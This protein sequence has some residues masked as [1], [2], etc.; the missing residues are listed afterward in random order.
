MPIRRDNGN[1]AAG[2]LGVCVADPLQ[3]FLPARRRANKV[4]VRYDGSASLGHVVQS[5]GIPLP[6]VGQLRSG[7]SVVPPSHR[8]HYGDVVD[9]TATA[10]PQ[11]LP[12]GRPRFALDVHLGSL[13]RRMR[14]LG[15]DSWYA[16][17]ATDD[18]L[19][20]LAH[21]ESRVLLTK[22]RALLCRRTVRHAAYVRGFTGDEQMVDVLDRF[23]PGLA[24][25]TRCPDCNG[26]AGLLKPGTARSYLEFAQCL[27]CAQVYWRGAHSDKLD[28][29]I[30]AAGDVV[31]RG[32]KQGVTRHDL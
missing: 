18:E 16:T 26:V 27:H 31:R 11:P 24:P 13:A 7:D 23:A 29:L 21:A 28:A 9:V 4:T 5:L 2:E 14:L 6:E 10:R 25:F 30:S 12:S 20:H 3:I 19:I 22:D 17:E 1:V 15:L 8:P 32:I